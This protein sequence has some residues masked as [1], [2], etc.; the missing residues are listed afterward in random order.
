MTFDEML[1]LGLQCKRY[2]GTA[3]QGTAMGTI[4][5]PTLSL[6]MGF[7]E[8]ELYTI[9]R[10]KFNLPISNYFEQSWKR[11]LDHCFLFL[12]LSSIKP[13]ELLHVLNIINPAIQFTMES[14][15]TQLPFLDVMI[16]K[17]GKKVFMDFYSKQTDS[18]RCLLQIKSPQALFEKYTIFSCSWNLHDCKIL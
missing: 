2:N 11:F 14:S 5:A 8:I 7:H 3:I 9:I 15:D 16:N 6:S 18:K 17:D 4:F 1:Y 13:N 12:R 10:N